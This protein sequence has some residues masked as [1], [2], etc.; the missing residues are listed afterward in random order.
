MY[1][2]GRFLHG[3]IAA[4]T[5]GV[6]DANGALHGFG[7]IPQGERPDVIVALHDRS[8]HWKLAIRP[9][10]Y[11]G[12]AYMDGSLEITRGSLWDFLQLCGRNLAEYRKRRTRECAA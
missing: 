1:L 8:L 10:L 5:I 2:L 7:A 4:G 12:E 6:I 11:L 3:F 9:D